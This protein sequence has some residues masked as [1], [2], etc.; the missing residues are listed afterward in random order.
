MNQYIMDQSEC[1]AIATAISDVTH[2]LCI[3]LHETQCMTLE[4]SRLSRA[5]KVE[6]ILQLQAMLNGV[7]RT[8]M[9]RADRIAR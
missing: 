8:G 5:G 6:T 1:A 7:R 9:Q 2:S 4:N 3:L